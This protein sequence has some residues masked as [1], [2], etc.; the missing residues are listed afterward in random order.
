VIL[1]AIGPLGGGYM[2]WELAL[3][4]APGTLLGLLGSATPVLSTVCLMGMFA[5]T[6]S[7]R[8]GGARYAVLLAAS[9]LIGAAVVLGRTPIRQRGETDVR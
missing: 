3:H 6:G 8:A 1:A 7:V 2:L 9:V 5:L 4:R